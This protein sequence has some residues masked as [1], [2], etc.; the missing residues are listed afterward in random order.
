MDDQ[1]PMP[2]NPTNDDVTVPQPPQQDPPAMPVD[3]SP[4]TDQPAPEDSQPA[5]DPAVPPTQTFGGDVP[6]APE[7]PAGPGPVETPGV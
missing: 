1:N 4:V 7:A 6:P 2:T 5:A 3:P